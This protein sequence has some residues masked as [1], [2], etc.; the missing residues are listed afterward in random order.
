V[1][2]FIPGWF[3]RFRIYRLFDDW[4]VEAKPITKHF[5]KAIA[6]HGAGTLSSPKP[7]T[8]PQALAWVAAFGSVSYV[9]REAGFIFYRPK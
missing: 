4:I 1:I 2:R 7:M 5:W 6:Y 3:P 9:D 8:E